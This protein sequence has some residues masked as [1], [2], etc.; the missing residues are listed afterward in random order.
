MILQRI[1]EYAAK[2]CYVLF[3][4]DIWHLMGEDGMHRNI[5]K[6][7]HAMASIFAGMGFRLV[8]LSQPIR[9][10]KELLEFG[11]IYIKE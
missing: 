2:G 8:H 5:T 4:S 6:S 11:A 1:S 10:P 3:W 7:Q 9:D